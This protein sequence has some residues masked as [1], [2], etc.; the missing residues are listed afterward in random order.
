[1]G[2]RRKYFLFILIL[3]LIVLS[4]YSL[5]KKSESSNP[6]DGVFVI[7]MIDS[8]KTDQT[9]QNKQYLLHPGA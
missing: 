7:T 3:I 5:S 6:N 2:F 8:D 1:M 9:V 4:L